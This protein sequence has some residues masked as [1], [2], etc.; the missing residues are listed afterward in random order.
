MTT[1]TPSTACPNCDETARCPGCRRA[2]RL[3]EIRDRVRHETHPASM[4]HTWAA[5]LRDCLAEVDRLTTALNQARPDALLEAAEVL[6]RN[7]LVAAAELVEAQLLLE[8]VH[9]PGRPA[10]R[11]DLHARILDGLAAWQRGESPSVV[12]AD[13]EQPGGDTLLLVGARCDPPDTDG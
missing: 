11:P 10:L 5:Y 7:D 3:A 4:P 8:A 13:P 2:V 6:R 12:L 1:D 9:T